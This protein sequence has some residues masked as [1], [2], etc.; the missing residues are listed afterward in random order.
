MLQ[1]DTQRIFAT[2]EMADLVR[3]FPWSTTP[4]GPIEQ[5][6]ETLVII[7]NTML[8][9]RHPM[10]L[11]WGPDLIQF[12]NDGY[13]PYLHSDKH[14]RALGQPGRECWPEIWHIISPQIEAVMSRGE[15]TW[16]EDALI[17][18]YRD[19]QLV[20][21]YWTYSYSPVR[22]SD[23]V[24]HGTLVTCSET[25]ARVLAERDLRTSEQRLRLAL[26]AS[27][28]IGTWDWD[29]AHDRVYSDARFAQLYG[30]EPQRAAEGVS[31]HEFT[32]NVH[33]DDRIPVQQAIAASIAEQRELA[34]EYRI[35]Q[36]DGSLRHVHARGRCTYGPS[37]E[38][39]RFP[40]IV[41]DITDRKHSET[42][43]HR[44][45]KLAAVGRLASSIAHEINNPLEAVTNLIYLS[46][47][48]TQSPETREYL[49]M[50]QQELARVANIVT[51][52]L[53]FH[54]Q[55]THA[56]ETLLSD[57]LDSV[58]T[59]LRGKISNSGV[60]IQRQYR[61]ESKIRAFDADL[62]QVFVNLI[63][64]AL[65]ATPRGC[66]ILRVRD[67]RHWTTGA[68]GVRVTVADNGTGMSTSTRLRIFEPFFTTKGATGTG[69]GLWVSSEI[70]RNHHAHLHVRSSQ[71]H[72]HRG[73]TFSIFLPH[74]SAN[75]P[76]E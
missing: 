55:S 61:S 65:D 75:I 48:S 59:L 42:I 56:R 44:T 14:P 35:L 7:V 25:T 15:A 28:G 45:E 47:N 68:P 69:L 10:F 24:I 37:G 51:Q 70:L 20:D 2:G 76:I 50:A 3:A 11:W 12:Y 38:P 54:R 30:V 16:F 29:V 72:P 31:L 36:R 9:T 27:N 66:L 53:R 19:H 63:T 32:R 18:I 58:L 26:S 1:P 39:L 22:S 67:A 71:S 49:G 34:V 62:R 52:T 43:L 23:G 46:A 64:N 13:R 5:W 60:N 73:T 4:I 41:I 33:P 40:G 8:S 57:V 21:V 74:T 6:P 17:P